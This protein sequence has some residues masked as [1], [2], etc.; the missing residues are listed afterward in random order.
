MKDVY[1][2]L[3]CIALF[4]FLSGWT[5][6]LVELNEDLRSQKARKRNR[7]W[8]YTKAAYIGV[9]CA[10]S[11]YFVFGLSI[12]SF[13]FWINLLALTPIIFNPTI[14]LFKKNGFFYLGE[15]GFEGNFRDPWWKRLL[16]YLI[17]VLI[18]IITFYIFS[19]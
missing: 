18:F 10:L 1:V 5:F 3:A 8:Y 7:M 2:T 11:S 19:K 14:N 4:N 9:I 12:V 13:V 6:A 17:F 15:N 16:Y